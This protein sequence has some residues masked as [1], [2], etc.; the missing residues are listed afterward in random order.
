MTIT[1][2]VTPT[3]RVT[4][5][6]RSLREVTVL[7]RDVTRVAF[8]AGSSGLG[9]LH[10]VEQQGAMRVSDLA[11]CS[12]VGVST[13]SRHVADLTATGLLDRELSADD[14]RTHVVR[15]TPAGRTALDRAR[16]DVLDRLL[17]ALQ[18][19]DDAELTELERQLARLTHD[20]TA[21]TGR[22]PERT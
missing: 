12:H 19:W 14:A 5:L 21:V 1:H 9:V 13:M 20:L 17:P 7:W 8:P 4:R 16:T 18:G 15:L 6:L 3:D 11:M 22:A 2:P 10:L